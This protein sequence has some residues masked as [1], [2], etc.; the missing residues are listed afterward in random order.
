MITCHLPRFS[1]FRIGIRCEPRLLRLTL[2]SFGFCAGSNEIVDEL[3]H[4]ES[5]VSFQRRFAAGNI[6]GTVV[7]LFVLVS[8]CTTQPSSEYRA[9][10][11]SVTVAP[12]QVVPPR[13]ESPVD[14]LLVENSGMMS[15]RPEALLRFADEPV[16]ALA[17]AN[18]CKVELLIPSK[19]FPKDRKT[20]AKWVSFED[21][22]LLSVL[23]MD[24][25][26]EDAVSQMPA[27]MTSLDGQL[28]RIRG[29]MY[30]AFQD[31]GL[32]GF[33][34]LRDNQECCYGPEAKVY[35]NLEIRMKPG[36][37]TSYVPLQRTLD[38]VGR[39]KIEMQAAGG[40]P[41]ALFKVED[42]AVMTR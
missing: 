8:G 28:V 39:F 37:T 17:I 40:K 27:W 6:I 3:P 25:V 5:A 2:L 29:Y 33:A 32:E 23:N 13:P 22:N 42:A 20:G 14:A 30:P 38:V 15:V 26:T 21:L 12:T 1:H 10:E 18:P 41:Y 24:P 31:E 35:D 4:Q 9:L 19:A 16:S 36:T 7:V 34:L 11:K